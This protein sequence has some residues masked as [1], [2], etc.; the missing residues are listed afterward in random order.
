MKLYTCFTPSHRPLLEQHFLPSL[1]AEFMHDKLRPKQIEQRSVTGEFGS[2]GFQATC[3]DKVDVILEA[4]RTETEP[5]LFSDVDVRFYGPVVDDLLKCLGDADMAFQWDGPRG[6]ECTGF[7]VLRPSPKL[8]RFWENVGDRMVDKDMMDQDAVHTELDWA[9][10]W[11]GDKLIKTVILPERYWTFGRNDKH[12]KPGMRVNPPAD[13]LVHHANWTVGV[14]NKLR[15]LEAVAAHQGV[16][17]KTPSGEPCHRSISNGRCVPY[18]MGKPGES[19]R[20]TSHE[21]IDL[22][23]RQHVT[24]ASVLEDLTP[25]DRDQPVARAYVPDEP[26]LEPILVPAD[27]ERTLPYSEVTR[28]LEDQR[29]KLTGPR[30]HPLPLALVLQFWK[31][32]KRRALDLARLLADLEP[33]RRTDV[34]FVFARQDNC[35]MDAEIAEAQLYVGSKFPVMDLVA[36]TDSDKK[37]PGVC[38]D[39]W[40]SAV[41]QLSD[42]YHTGRLPYGNVFLFEADGCPIGSDWVDRLKRS[43]EETLLLGKRVTGPLIRFGGVDAVHQVGGHVNGTLVMHLSCWEDHPSLRRCPSDAAY[44]VFHGLVLRNEAGPSQIIRNEHG[45]RGLSES[46]YWV[47]AKESCWITSLKDSSHHHWARRMLEAERARR[48]S[49]DTSGA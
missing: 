17:V 46:M 10:K 31:G 21:V 12:W 23:R 4:L 3:L 29:R 49:E 24:V 48:D 26:W 7:M 18:Y 41:Q 5:F 1:P 30:H 14:E 38:F 8:L 37:Y 43:H 9:K 16:M 34:V 20:A 27:G 13:M 19:D 33:A 42:A 35:P 25:S 2:S 44:D 39:P 45:A 32:D 28:M 15:L 6:R 36:K 40:A 11:H 47:I 22:N